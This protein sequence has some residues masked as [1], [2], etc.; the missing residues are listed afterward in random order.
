MPAEDPLPDPARRRVRARWIVAA[1]VLVAGGLIGGLSLRP[2]EVPVI[3]VQPSTLVRTLQFS[4]RVATVSRVEVG[5]TVTG[6]VQRVLIQE[7]AQVRAGQLLIELEEDELR[8]AWRQAQAS[9]VQMAATLR[10]AREEL[11]RVQALV[12]QGFVTASRADDARRAVD[13]AQAQRDANRAA[14]EVARARLAQ[15]RIAAPTAARV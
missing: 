1:L 11:Q 12:A 15:A 9:E 10:N 8:A 7:G 3:V 2:A 5:A 13:V 6:R 14:T 4:A